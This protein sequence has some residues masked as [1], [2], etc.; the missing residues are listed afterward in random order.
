MVV[1]GECLQICVMAQCSFVMGPDRCPAHHAHTLSSVRVEEA[2]A[3][4]VERVRATGVGR[5][6][7]LAEEELKREVQVVEVATGSAVAG[8]KGVGSVGTQN[9]MGQSILCLRLTVVWAA[10]SIDARYYLICWKS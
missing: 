1:V 4:V 2:E 3:P 7:Q 5:V 9:D 8:M 6:L 10:A